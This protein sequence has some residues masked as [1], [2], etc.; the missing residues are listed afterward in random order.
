MILNILESEILKEIVEKLANLTDDVRQFKALSSANDALAANLTE[1][2]KKLKV[3]SSANAALA[4]NLTEEVKQ[5]K[6]LS[7]ANVALV[8]NLTEEVR[9]SKACCSANEILVANLTEQFNQ[10][11]DLAEENRKRHENVDLSFAHLCPLLDVIFDVSSPPGGS[12]Y[13]CCHER[14]SGTPGQI[15][16]AMICTLD[17]YLALSQVFPQSETRSCASTCGD[18]SLIPIIQ[19]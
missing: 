7:S 14:Y 6:A 17:G 16:N 10:A 8:D 18:L 12:R 13:D 19:N 1:E 9:Q 15:G 11:K 5:L 4:G 3:S 2:V